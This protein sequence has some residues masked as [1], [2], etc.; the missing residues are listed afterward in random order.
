MGKEAAL[1]IEMGTRQNQ[2]EYDLISPETDPS[3][4]GYVSRTGFEKQT[5]FASGVGF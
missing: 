1:S 4:G 2:R 5:W 3:S